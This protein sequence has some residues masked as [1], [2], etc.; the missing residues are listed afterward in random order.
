VASDVT[1]DAAIPADARGHFKTVPGSAQLLY[2][3]PA[4]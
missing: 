3:D 1:E 4:P 2:F